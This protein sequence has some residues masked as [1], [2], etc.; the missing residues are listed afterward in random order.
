M[1]SLLL[2]CLLLVLGGCAGDEAAT[3]E[4]QLAKPGTSKD[5]E[6]VKAPPD[7][8]KPDAAPK[9]DKK[10]DATPTPDKLTLAF[11]GHFGAD[12]TI[13]GTFTYVLA[14]GPIGTNVRNL[15]PNVIYE[16]DSWEL[17]VNSASYESH[18]ASGVYSK[19]FAGNSV[20]FCL[21]NCQFSSPQ[22]AQLTFKNETDRILIL[23]FNMTD[24]TPFINPPSTLTEWGTFRAA[25]SSMYRVPCPVC[26]PVSLLLAGTL[27]EPIESEATE[28]T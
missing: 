4:E 11:S 12:T 7:V 3:P 24:P 19:A 22:V 27:T 25:G 17:T 13:Q 14:Q 20:E 21:G 1:L 28:T 10:P 5:P 16:M 26:S 23:N 2:V 6:H 18:I 8:P 9:P 15:T